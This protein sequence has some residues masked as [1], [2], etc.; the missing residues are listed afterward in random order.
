LTVERLTE[1]MR[2]QPFGQGN[3][4][5]QFLVPQVTL[6][7]PPQKL[8][9]EQQHWKF[10]IT[11]GVAFLEVLWWGGAEG[12]TAPPSGTFDVAVVPQLETYNG[13]TSVRLKFLDWRPS[14]VT[15][16]V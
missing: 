12:G 6:A 13:R 7:G 16:V 4:A 14:T 9:R 10:R 1:L 2:L 8:G 11:D 15:A 3:P 5:L